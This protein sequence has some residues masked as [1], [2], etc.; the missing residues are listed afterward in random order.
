MSMELFILANSMTASRTEGILIFP[1]RSVYKGE[2]VN[3]HGQGTYEHVRWSAQT[4][5]FI[6]S[7]EH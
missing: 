6:D 2:F 3:G 5:E 7:I 1:D 4:G